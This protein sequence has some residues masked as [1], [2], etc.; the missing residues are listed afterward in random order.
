[1]DEE[2]L[3]PSS[4]S[5]H[6]HPIDPNSL[7]AWKKWLLATA[8]R[9]SFGLGCAIVSLL[10]IVVATIVIVV[11]TNKT[12]EEQE[13]VRTITM[14]ICRMHY[15]TALTREDDVRLFCKRLLRI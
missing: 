6:D 13:H 14:E 9:N 4:S 1:M 11:L 5:D 10:V 7:D 15:M 12:R 8:R 2:T 3:L